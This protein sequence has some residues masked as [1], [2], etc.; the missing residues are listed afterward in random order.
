MA[1]ELLVKGV[2]K[3]LKS[4]QE[5]GKDFHFAAL[6]PVYPG[7]PST[8]YVLLLDGDWLQN[9]SVFESR[10]LI[11]ERIFKSIDEPEIRKKINS[12][13]VW[14]RGNAFQPGIEA[15]ILIDDKSISRFFNYA[16]AMSFSGSL[17][18]GE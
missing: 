18:S 4:F 14:N 16:P 5:E 9:I 12:I 13:S 8:S 10:K 2:Q 1:K 7:L 6:V 15:E 17:F 3:V 11:I